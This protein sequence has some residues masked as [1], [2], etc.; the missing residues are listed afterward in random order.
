MQEV[1][2]VVLN[3]LQ[4]F[5]LF[6]DPLARVAAFECFLPT[7]SIVACPLISDGSGNHTFTKLSIAE[8]W[9]RSDGY[10]APPVNGVARHRPTESP[11]RCLVAELAVLYCKFVLMFLYILQWTLVAAFECFLPTASSVACAWNSDG[12]GHH[13]FTTLSFAESWQR[14]DGYPA[15]LVNGVATGALCLVLA[16]VI[17]ACSLVPAACCLM[18]GAFCPWCP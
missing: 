17:G 7:A 6:F 9:Q 13:T 18:S 12:S 1:W 8:S 11:Q 3:T 16:Q 2:L 14:F 4:C 5:A 10:P 15:P